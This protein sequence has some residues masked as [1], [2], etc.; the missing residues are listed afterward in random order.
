[1]FQP[2]K[3]INLLFANAQDTYYAEGLL[4]FEDL[5][6]YI[7][8]LIHKELNYDVVYFL[9]ERQSQFEVS[10]FGEKKYIRFE[11]K[12]FSFKNT[13]KQ[14]GEWM[15][16]RLKDEKIKCAFVCSL[17]DFCRLLERKDYEFLLEE[18]IKLESSTERRGFI[19]LTAPTSVEDS[20][21]LLLESPVFANQVVGKSLGC[22]CAPILNL[23]Y[24]TNEHAFDYLYDELSR[25]MRSACTFLNRFDGN[26]I[27]GIMN[28][29]ILRENISVKECD[30]ESMRVYLNDILNSEEFYTGQILR[31]FFEDGP[32]EFRSLYKKLCSPDNRKL[33]KTTYDYS[34]FV[35]KESMV[36]IF[37]RD[38]TIRQC[39]TL[40]L[41][42]KFS[43]CTRGAEKL[44][45]MKKLLRKVKNLKI[46]PAILTE[47]GTTVSIYNEVLQSNNADERTLC[48][49]L[50]FL[51]YCAAW[52]YAEAGSDQESRAFSLSEIIGNY[53]SI[54]EAYLTTRSSKHNSEISAL[55]PEARD[56]YKIS[57]RQLEVKLEQYET[58]LSVLEQGAYAKMASAHTGPCDIGISAA[59]ILDGLYAGEPAKNVTAPGAQQPVEE[60]SPVVY[61]ED[62]VLTDYVFDE[63]PEFYIE[64]PDI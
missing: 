27:D 61:E 36:P 12:S 51:H 14:F 4:K 7:W 57:M 41:P 31:E 3:L 47:M 38:P 24:E 32:L 2:K 25:Q 13:Q 22:L 8:Y 55:T 58:K 60:D 40:K 54:R 26:T 34:D 39:M 19:L 44:L 6:R 18:L 17:G 59:E 43:S 46:N 28:H 15:K 5:N 45:E 21:E 11:P 35:G 50:S 53:M 23:R 37:Y 20:K 56:I 16:E 1:M 9:K 48:L 30:P 49:L 29:L 64:V 63:P 62:P 10:G 52:L 42:E 33:I